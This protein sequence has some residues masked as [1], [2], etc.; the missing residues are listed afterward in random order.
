MVW[1]D[2]RPVDRNGAGPL[3]GRVPRLPGRAIAHR[4]QRGRDPRN[5]N[6]LQTQFPAITVT[7][8]VTTQPII[9]SVT[10]SPVVYF[11][12]QDGNED[13][14]NPTSGATI[15]QRYLGQTPNCPGSVPANLG[16]SSTATVAPV[17]IG[18]QQIPLVFAGG[19]NPN[20]S[21]NQSSPFF[22]A[23]NATAGTI[24]WATALDVPPVGP[25][26][27]DYL[28]SSA[29]LYPVGASDP[30]IYVG[31]ASIGDCPLVQGALFKLDAARERSRR[32]FRPCPLAASVAMYGAALLS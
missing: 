22:Y 9:S 19:N 14:I 18:D 27:H 1:G 8:G 28:W 5:V 29:A 6:P 11:G 20:A 12:G 21:P 17:T 13:A 26:P 25:N 16:V 2:G 3:C 15:W 24:R 7:G 31:L 23:L 4:A 32:S 30:S 10:N